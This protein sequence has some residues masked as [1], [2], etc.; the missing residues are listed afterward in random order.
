MDNIFLSS[1]A[2]QA[3]QSTNGAALIFWMASN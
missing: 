3:G 1:G 2:W